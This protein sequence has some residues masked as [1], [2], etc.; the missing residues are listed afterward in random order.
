MTGCLVS[1]RLSI[2]WFFVWA[3]WLIGL[4]AFR[5]LVGLVWSVGP[6]IGRFD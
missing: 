4:S 3:G 5:G 1:L 2:S 6:S